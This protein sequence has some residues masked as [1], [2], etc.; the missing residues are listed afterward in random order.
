MKRS[1]VTLESVDDIAYTLDNHDI[2]ENDDNSARRE[3]M[4][5]LLHVAIEIALTEKQKKVIKMYLEGKTKAE[6]AEILQIS[7]QAVHKL[8]KVAK[9]K[10]INIKNFSEM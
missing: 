8:L 10:L 9:K 3:E 2:S 7:R 1:H 4:K 5:R 6:M